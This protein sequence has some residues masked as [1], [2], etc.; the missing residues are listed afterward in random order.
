MVDNKGLSKT[1]VKQNQKTDRSFESLFSN[2]LVLRNTEEQSRVIR[3]LKDYFDQLEIR[4][5]DTSKFDFDSSN[6]FDLCKS[7]L[8]LLEKLFN[9]YGLHQAERE[10]RSKFSKAY[11]GLYQENGG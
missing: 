3:D 7:I 4:E 9:L 1:A 8:K 5:D 11:K 6:G 2:T 10:Y